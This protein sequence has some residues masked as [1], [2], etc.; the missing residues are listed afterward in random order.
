MHLQSL[1]NVTF[2]NSSGYI[3]RQFEDL[4]AHDLSKEY[5]EELIPM[6]Q[7]INE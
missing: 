5:M 6:P 7:Q 2:Y 3:A 1:Y 4:N